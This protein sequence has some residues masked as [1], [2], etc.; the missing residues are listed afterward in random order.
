MSA[1]VL[2]LWIFVKGSFHF[3]FRA[4]AARNMLVRF[5]AN[6]LGISSIILHHLILAENP[7]L[8]SKAFLISFDL[9]WVFCDGSSCCSS[10]EQE[11]KLHHGYRYRLTHSFMWWWFLIVGLMNNVKQWR[12]TKIN[13]LIFLE[14]DFSNLLIMHLHHFW[15][16]GRCEGTLLER[17]PRFY[18]TR[19]L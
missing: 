9:G 8:S 17:G 13:V 15:S 18:M 19:I 14:Y 11:H 1:W 5:S 10:S 2:I 3:V 6:Y 4:A 7:L 12:I 16:A